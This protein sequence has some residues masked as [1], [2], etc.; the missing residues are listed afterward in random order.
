L[1]QIPPG[2]NAL[3]V[4]SVADRQS[5]QAILRSAPALHQL[6]VVILEGF[7]EPPPAAEVWHALERAPITLVRCHQGRLAEALQSLERL[8]EPALYQIN[9]LETIRARGG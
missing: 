8:S 1:S 2:A 5:L 4:V 6:A 7:G 3:V 9:D